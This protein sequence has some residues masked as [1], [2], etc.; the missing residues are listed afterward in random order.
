MNILDKICSNK[1]KEINFDKNKCSFRTL[2]QL[3]KNE[4]N[5]GFN[6]LLIKKHN[7]FLIE[8]LRNSCEIR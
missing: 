6:S 5:R 4:P 8:F 3:T 7:L 2:E 1:K